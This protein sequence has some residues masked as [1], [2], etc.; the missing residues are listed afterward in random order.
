[1]TDELATAI[2]KTDD[3]RLGLAHRAIL[4]T[5]SD[6]VA[7]TRIYS[8]D[9]PSMVLGRYFA[10]DEPVEYKVDARWY[11]NASKRWVD[12]Q[13]PHVRITE[14]ELISLY[15]AFIVWTP[16]EPEPRILELARAINAS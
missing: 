12:P 1:M 15:P 4:E 14:E 5:E 3:T 8:N 7:R 16:D 11:S 9:L 6:R 13:Q 10:A 2:A